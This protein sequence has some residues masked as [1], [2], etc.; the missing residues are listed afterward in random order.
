MFTLPQVKQVGF[1]KPLSLVI[2]VNKK[3]ISTL[4]ILLFGNTPC[5]FDSSGKI[6]LSICEHSLKC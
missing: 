2:V 3:A 4:S 6:Q 5:F 1:P